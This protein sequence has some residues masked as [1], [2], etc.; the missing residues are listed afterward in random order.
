MAPFASQL[1]RNRR[2]VISANK[3]TT[4]GTVL[5]DGALTH[6]L[7]FEG[8]N[9]PAA[10]EKEYFSD[11]QLAKGFP[12]AS[13][14]IEIQRRSSLQLSGLPVYDFLAGWLLAMAFGKVVT[15][16][17]GTPW[18]HT[19]TEDLSTT[20]APVTTVYIEET[21]DEKYKMQDVAIDSLRF[22]GGAIGPVLCDAT[23]RGSGR[24]LDGSMTPPALVDPVFILNN[25]A[26]I[27]LGA[28]AGA[29]SIKERIRSWEINIGTPQEDYRHP[30][31]GLYAGF[32]RRGDLSPSVKLA[33]AAKDT[34]DIRTLLISDTMQELQININSAAGAQLN[35][36]FPNLKFRGVGGEDGQYIV[37]NIEADESS[38]FR[39]GAAER[40]EVV[41]ING[42]ATYLV[43]A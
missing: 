11:A 10:P 8:R 39:I 38:I 40:V 12:G 43:A 35:F 41:V 5:A 6:N 19:F 21:A 3:Q 16:G 9:F 42:Q 30:G 27:L 22:S 37:W 28:P 29:T 33:V 36:K 15:T 26:D 13:T 18:T 31:S 7:R 2:V 20:L 25:D 14:R 17:A 23:L 24:H 32:H 34:D 4:Y 1:I